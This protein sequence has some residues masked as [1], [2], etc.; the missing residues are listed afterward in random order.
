MTTSGGMGIKLKI[1]QGNPQVARPG[2]GEDDF[3]RK[4]KSSDRGN[5]Q[6]K[7]S[8]PGQSFEMIIRVKD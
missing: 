6:L 3:L 7:D 4:I 5:R 8:A 2:E 1:C